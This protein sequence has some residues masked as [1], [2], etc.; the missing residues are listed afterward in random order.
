MITDERKS[1]IPQTAK[2]VMDLFGGIDVI[3]NAKLSDIA[4]DPE[5]YENR[6]VILEDLMVYKVNV[7]M[8]FHGFFGPSL[9]AKDGDDSITVYCNALDNVWVQQVAGM[10]QVGDRILAMGEIP[11][12]GRGD[13]YLRPVYIANKS[14]KNTVYRDTSGTRSA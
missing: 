3:L 13:L 11:E 6:H 10:T 5:K 4:K 9:R 2:E 8:S 7:G 12:K 1:Y 14:L